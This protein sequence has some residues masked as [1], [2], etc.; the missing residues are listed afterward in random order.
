MG[1]QPALM[2]RGSPREVLIQRLI[3]DVFAGE[4]LANLR[5]QAELTSVVREVEVSIGRE[6]IHGGMEQFDAISL[7][8]K[9]RIG[10]L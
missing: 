3:C 7:D 1:Q 9:G 8:V 2:R 5:T 4:V 6:P 10:T